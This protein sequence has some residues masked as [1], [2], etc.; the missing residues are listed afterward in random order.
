ML[1]VWII[2]FIHVLIYLFILSC[3]E[4]SKMKKNINLH[5]ENNL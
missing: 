2:K 3:I 5:N 4:A 1:L